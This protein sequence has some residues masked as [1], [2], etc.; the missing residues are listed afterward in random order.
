M[1]RTAILFVLAAA[2][3]S[4]GDKPETTET[5]KAVDSAATAAPAAEATPAPPALDSATKAKNAETYMMPGEMQKLMASMNGKWSGDVTMYVPTE[6]KSKVTIEYNMIMGG[7][8][9]VMKYKG[10]MMGMPFEGM[11]TM[12]YDNLRKVFTNTWIDNMSTSVMYMEGN[13]DAATKTI[14]MKGKSTDPETGAQGEMRQV[15]KMLD[16]KT[17]IMEMYMTPPGGQEM[18]FME[19]KN[20][21]G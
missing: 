3:S 4:C 19:S 20:T 16:D 9:Q 12:G 1:K 8:F 13:Y 6:S 5:P 2:L 14:D 11:G 17:T 18:K 10:T 15:M 21:K 7:R